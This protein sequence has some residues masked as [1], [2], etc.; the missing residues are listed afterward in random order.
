[1]TPEVDLSLQSQ[2]D[3]DMAKWFDFHKAE[4]E[5]LSLWPLDVEPLLW[6][7]GEV[8]DWDNDPPKFSLLW[9]QNSGTPIRIPGPHIQT[10]LFG[11]TVAEVF[12]DFPID[13]CDTPSPSS[14]PSLS[15]VSPVLLP[16]PIDEENRGQL[17]TNDLSD[18]LIDDVSQ[19]LS[20]RVHLDS[21]PQSPNPLSI[22]EPPQSTPPPLSPSTCNPLSINALSDTFSSS[23]S[24]LSVGSSSNAPSTYAVSPSPKPFFTASSSSSP[25]PTSRLRRSPGRSPPKHFIGLGEPY[26]GPAAGTQSTPALDITMQATPNQIVLEEHPQDAARRRRS[27][28]RGSYPEDDEDPE[29]P[30][31][32]ADARPRKRVVTR[33]APKRHL[34]TVP[35]CWESFTRFNDVQRHIKNAAIHKGTTQQAEALAASST[36][37]KYCGEELSRADAARRHELKSSCGKRTIRRKSTYSMLPA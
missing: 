14:S 32:D 10:N 3:E 1:M 31:D 29:P 28:K 33:G 23:S 2:E 24:T 37:C 20:D 15:P 18:L 7:D 19:Q 22:S 12:A 25:A 26:A 34:C 27:A 8:P 21:P 17:P 16:S 5:P 11:R 9:R 6:F 30:M 35:G 13:F 36:V 4:E